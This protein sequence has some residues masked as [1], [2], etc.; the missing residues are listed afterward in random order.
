MLKKLSA[1]CPALAKENTGDESHLV[2]E[3]AFVLFGRRARGEADKR[4]G[5]TRIFA[6]DW[7]KI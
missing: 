7:L 4:F 2:S 6:P 1:I 5:G 3:V